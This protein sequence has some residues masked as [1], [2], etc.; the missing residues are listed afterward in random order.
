VHSGKLRHK[1]KL[2]SGLEGLLEMVGLEMSELVHIQ[3]M[4][5]GAGGENSRR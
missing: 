5:Q 4:I 1:R 3:P 2:L